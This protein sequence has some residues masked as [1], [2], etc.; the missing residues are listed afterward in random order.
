MDI[1]NNRSYGFSLIEK[2]FVR[3]CRA[4]SVAAVGV[5]TSY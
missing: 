4:V 1:N 5:V 3:D 2:I